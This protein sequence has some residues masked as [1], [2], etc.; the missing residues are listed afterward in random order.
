MLSAIIL[1]LFGHRRNKATATSRVIQ[2]QE[3]AALDI[4]I[5]SEHN[6][7]LQ[8]W[9]E[10][11]GLTCELQIFCPSWQTREATTLR[12]RAYDQIIEVKLAAQTSTVEAMRRIARLLEPLLDVTLP[13]PGS[14]CQR[15]GLSME[16]KTRHGLAASS[17]DGMVIVRCDGRGFDVEVGLDEPVASGGVISLALDGAVERVTTRAGQHGSEVLRAMAEALTRLGALVE[18]NSQSCEDSLCGRVDLLT[19]LPVAAARAAV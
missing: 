3:P 16:R 6:D 10:H 17:T 15:L 11:D 19:L 7:D 9:L 14:H 4:E 12:L 18:L 13:A 1:P 5:L 8:V 2:R